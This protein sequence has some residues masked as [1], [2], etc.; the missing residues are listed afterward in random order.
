MRGCRNSKCHTLRSLK[1]FTHFFSRSL[2]SAYNYIIAT[3]ERKNLQKF[4]FLK[5]DDKSI[6]FT[7]RFG[8]LAEVLLQAVSVGAT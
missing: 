5:N 3:E 6:C 1:E 7:L 8:G 4:S 2:S